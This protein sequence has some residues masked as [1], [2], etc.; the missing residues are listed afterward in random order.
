METGAHLTSLVDFS[1]EELM[2]DVFLNNQNHLLP[3]A[4]L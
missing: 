2:L 1:H 4:L 3:F